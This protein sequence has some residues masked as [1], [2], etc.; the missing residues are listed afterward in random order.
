MK[1]TDPYFNGFNWVYPKENTTIFKPGDKV[2]YI[3]KDKYGNKHLITPTI[4]RVSKKFAF[5]SD[6]VGEFRVPLDKIRPY[7]EGDEKIILSKYA[8]I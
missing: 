1:A 4:K 8:N 5:F 6:P 7:K 2:T 3:Y